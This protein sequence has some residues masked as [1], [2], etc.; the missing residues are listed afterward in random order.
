MY[1][2]V[3]P[4]WRAERIVWRESCRD[5][6]DTERSLH[7]L[8]RFHSYRQWPDTEVVLTQPDRRP[9]AVG[10]AAP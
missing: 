7:L 9:N 1:L 8:V 2:T 5:D 3:F 6:R 10:P 4:A